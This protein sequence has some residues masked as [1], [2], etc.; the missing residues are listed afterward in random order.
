MTIKNRLRK[1]EQIAEQREPLIGGRKQAEWELIR[2]KRI[3]LL[4]DPE[5][6]ERL[7]EQAIR[8]DLAG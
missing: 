6:L 4:N 3:R 2:A 1:L 7:R 8:L 5:T